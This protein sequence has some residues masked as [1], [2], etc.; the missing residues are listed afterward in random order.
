MPHPTNPKSQQTTPSLASAREDAQHE[1]ALPDVS[2]DAATNGHSPATNGKP[3]TGEEQPV[4]A[5]PQ[6]ALDAVGRKRR[7]RYGT[8]PTPPS[9]VKVPY[10]KR[11]DKHDTDEGEAIAWLTTQREWAETIGAECDAVWN[12]RPPKGPCGSYPTRELEAVIFFASMCGFRTYRAARNFLAS[13]RGQRACAALL[14]VGRTRQARYAKEQLLSPGIPSEATMSRHRR[15]FPDERRLRAYRAYFDRLRKRSAQDPLLREG[16]RHLYIDGSGQPTSLTCPKYDLVTGEILNA[17]A[18]TCPEGGFIGRDAPEA[19]R[20]M[21]FGVVPLTCINAL[22]WA[23]DHGPINLSEGESA[24]RALEDFAANV[25]PLLGDP[26]LRVLSADSGFQKTALRALVRTMSIVENISS[27]SHTIHRASTDRERESADRRQLDIGGYDN[28]FANGHRELQCRCGHAEICRR[29]TLQGKRAVVRVEGRCGTCGNVTITSGL[30]KTV[31]DTT[32]PT[33]D[34]RGT[35]K[36]VRV[37]NGDPDD[38]IDWAFGNPLTF[39]DLLA[40]EYGRMRFAYGEGFNGACV[41]RFKLLKT[42]GYYRTKAQAELHAVTVFCAMHGLTQYRREL[43]RAAAAA[44][45]NGSAKAN[46]NVCALPTA[47]PTGGADLRP[48]A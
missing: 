14:G 2:A 12:A 5:K 41:S 13:D 40:I 3:L 1:Q 27:V 23:Y 38:V 18:I 17:G 24:M 8:L 34:P 20:G 33:A 32:R 35:L 46:G 11:H 48:A 47:S 28:W 10:A 30:W 9:E 26:Q 15:N 42:K 6:V 43:E 31:R 21:G 16:L 25:L 37:Q 45:V 19:K 44:A 39:Y 4:S 7:K 29:I 36:L 22:P